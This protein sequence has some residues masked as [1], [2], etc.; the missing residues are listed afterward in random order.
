M[1]NKR[2][3]ITGT[4][5]LADFIKR[6]FEA[7][8]W[9]GGTFEIKQLRIEDILVN[10]TNCWIFD[11]NNKKSCCDILINHAHKD[12]DQVKILD[13]ADRVWRNNPD[14]M[15]I[16]ISSRA[17]QP[18]IS[19]GHLYASQK[20]ALNHFANNLT[21]NSDRQYKMTTLNLGLMN[22]DLPSMNYTFVA[23]YIYQLITSY[24]DIEFTEVTMCD[25]ANYRDVQTLKESIK[26]TEKMQWELYPNTGNID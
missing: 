10:G 16:N 5:K 18:N 6:T 4:T 24:P 11:E 20:A 13:I 9:M 19:K 2:I 3:A 17:A 12:F 26:D 14:K 22:S 21:Y 8:P 7:S 25:R 1:P 23:G 15:I